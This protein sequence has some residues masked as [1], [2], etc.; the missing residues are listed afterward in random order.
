MLEFS[1]PEEKAPGVEF[2][3]MPLEDFDAS[4][5]VHTLENSSLN[6]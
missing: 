2:Y 5:P 3:W 6:G 4:G 1:K